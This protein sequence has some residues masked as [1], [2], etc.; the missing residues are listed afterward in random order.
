M[1]NKWLSHSWSSKNTGYDITHNAT[2][3]NDSGIVI[4]H[5]SHIF[6]SKIFANF[7]KVPVR[8]YTVTNISI[9]IFAVVKRPVI[10]NILYFIQSEIMLKMCV[11]NMT[12]PVH[13][14]NLSVNPSVI[15][16]LLN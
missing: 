4:F 2:N 16:I 13:V 3:S 12:Q 8:N 10:T 6:G 14:I 7:E 1:L 11:S 9:W 15:I 5:V